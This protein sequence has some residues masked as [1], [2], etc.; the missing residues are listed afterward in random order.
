MSR[1][2]ENSS[3]KDGA[4]A[5]RA[6]P[7]RRTQEERSSTTRKKLIEAAIELL[8]ERGYSQLTIANVAHRAGV[9]SGAMQHHFFTKS[10]LLLGV[11]ESIFIFPVLDI[12]LESLS[13]TH[14]TP[15]ARIDAIIDALWKIYGAPEYFVMWEVALGARVEPSVV[16]AINAYHLDY[17]K[18]M[19]RSFE[20][21]L[22]Q[23]K[24][25]R[26][27][28]SDLI[29]LTSSSMRGLAL[30]RAFGNEIVR[31]SNIQ[32]IK[33]AAHALIAKYQGAPDAPPRRA[34]KGAKPRA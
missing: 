27:L 11:L 25:T 34:R 2:I 6:R 26:S 5:R 19:E 9:T 21:I 14:Q 13:S 29:T 3:L 10:E 20:G 1:D 7:S 4:G 16:A 15:I 24:Q 8:H 32:L 18:R 12:P 17:A 30:M 23:A 33:D 28:V 31:P 22:P